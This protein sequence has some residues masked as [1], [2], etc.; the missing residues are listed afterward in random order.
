M[1]Y[2]KQYYNLSN[3]NLAASFPLLSWYQIHI[4]SICT[5]AWGYS[6]RWVLFNRKDVECN[7]L[8]RPL[9]CDK[10]KGC[11]LSP[12]YKKW[13]DSVRN[14]MTNKD[15]SFFL[16]TSSFLISFSYPN[17]SKGFHYFSP[18]KGAV[19]ARI[20]HYFCTFL[21]ISHPNTQSKWMISQETPTL[22]FL[23]LPNPSIQWG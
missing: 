17:N 22:S 6:L 20:Q 10:R 1:K 5:T 12:N 14:T 7:H 8:A 2:R 11:R 19:F 9:D 18:S 3:P 21:S 23:F 13:W 15:S 4:F 16:C